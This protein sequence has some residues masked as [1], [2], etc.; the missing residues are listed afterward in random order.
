[1]GIAVKNHSRIAPALS[2][3]DLFPDGPLSP[4]NR[5]ISR[6]LRQ[7]TAQAAAR[8]NKREQSEGSKKVLRF[9]NVLTSMF[10]Y[11]PSWLRINFEPS[12]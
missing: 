4:I 1:L 9:T 2:T 6:V 11:F 8:Q 7:D 3:G 10:L 12:P 5:P